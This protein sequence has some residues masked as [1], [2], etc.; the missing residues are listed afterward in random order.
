M[1]IEEEYID[2][3]ST[4]GRA[5]ESGD[6]RLANKSADKLL[7]L[8]D[9]LYSLED[10]GESILLSLTVH[11]DFSVKAWA[12]ADLL[13]V[14]EA[15]A[16]KVLRYVIQNDKGLAAFDAQIVIEEWQ[17]GKKEAAQ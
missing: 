15:E 13:P 17:A 8:R 9:L 11:S 2:S 14:N 10:R 5:T 1:N 12:G 7:K 16:L 3:A 4:H 6:Y